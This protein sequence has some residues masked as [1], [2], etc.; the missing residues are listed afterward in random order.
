VAVAEVAARFNFSADSLTNMN[1]YDLQ[2]WQDLHRG[3]C[4]AEKKEIEGK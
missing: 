3:L 2:Y 1:K 4:E